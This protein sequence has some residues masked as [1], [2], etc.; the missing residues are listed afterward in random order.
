[1]SVLTGCPG[2]L[3][4]NALYIN[5]RALALLRLLLLAM[6]MCSWLCRHRRAHHYASYSFYFVLERASVSQRARRRPTWRELW[7]TCPSERPRYSCKQQSCLFAC[8]TS[9]PAPFRAVF[10]WYSHKRGQPNNDIFCCQSGCIQLKHI[11]H[12]A[13]S[14]LRQQTTDYYNIGSWF[15][16]I[17]PFSTRT[18]SFLNTYDDEQRDEKSTE[19]RVIIAD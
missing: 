18:I 4:Q 9:L 7:T 8:L 1:M 12:N 2:Y 15:L 14:Y 10:T 13:K 5:R 17:Y 11:T 3:P 19:L 16:I 6:L